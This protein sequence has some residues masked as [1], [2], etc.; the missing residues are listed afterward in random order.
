VPGVAVAARSDGSADAAEPYAV[1]QT[2]DQGRFRLDGLPQGSYWVGL[3]PSPPPAQTE[4]GGELPFHSGRFSV[5]LS[6]ERPAPA[7]VPAPLLTDPPPLRVRGPGDLRFVL[8]SAGGFVTGRVVSDSGEPVASFQLTLL[9]YGRLVPLGTESWLVRQPEGV[10]REA[11]DAGLWAAEIAATGHAVHRTLPFRIDGGSTADL[12]FIRL[13]RGSGLVGTVTDAQGQAVP[14][15][16][17]HVLGSDWSTSERRP[18]TGLDGTF[19]LKDL[20]A[21]TYTLFAVSPRHPI[22]VVPAVRVEEGQTSALRVRLPPPVPVV[23]R[24]VDEFG[25]PVA[26]AEISATLP[27]LAPLSS[28]TLDALE[29]PAWGSNVADAD[30]VV[31]KPFAPP[32]PVVVTVRARGFAEKTLAVVLDPAEEVRFEVVLARDGK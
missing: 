15:A 14:F 31:R 30:G 2:D 24:I 8:A 22:G 20:A 27:A 16:R 3:L 23:L 32:G 11:V 29:P 26:G 1:G 28:R 7:S 4:L 17:I 12:G 6:R 21:G 5:W 9:R 13:G 19:E 10:F 25:A 18:Y